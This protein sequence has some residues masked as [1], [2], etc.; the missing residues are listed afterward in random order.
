MQVASKVMEI[1]F[2]L[3]LDGLEQLWKHSSKRMKRV[4]DCELRT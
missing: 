3:N 2:Q 1:L 4:L